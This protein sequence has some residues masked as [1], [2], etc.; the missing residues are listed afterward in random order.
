MSNQMH[1]KKEKNFKEFIEQEKNKGKTAKT[2]M[3]TITSINTAIIYSISFLIIFVVIAAIAYL[4][5]S[6]G[7][8]VW[9]GILLVAAAI[10]SILASRITSTLKNS[11]W[12]Y[13]N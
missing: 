7:V 12:K 2:I 13:K 11:Q 3:R 1:S 8:F 4:A 5:I 6:P 10:S 9:A